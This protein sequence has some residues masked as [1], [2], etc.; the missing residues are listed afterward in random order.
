MIY[1]LSCGLWLLLFN[2]CTLKCQSFVS[3]ITSLL[4]RMHIFKNFKCCMNYF[5]SGAA[6]CEKSI[7][8]FIKNFCFNIF[9]Y[10]GLILRL[11]VDGHLWITREVLTSLS[12]RNELF[13]G[14]GLLVSSLK[15]PFNS[16]PV[17]YTYELFGF[18][19]RTSF[20][21]CCHYYNFFKLPLHWEK[22]EE[23]WKVGLDQGLR[24]WNTVY[25]IASELLSSML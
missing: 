18:W 9:K 10:C 21:Y 12:W 1:L 6:F 3:L 11:M 24:M 5:Y 14:W 17:K 22:E 16:Y 8:G 2:L 23:S 7:T 25:T 4:F 19:F 13:R 20:F 15:A